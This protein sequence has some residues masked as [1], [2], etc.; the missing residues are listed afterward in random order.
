MLLFPAR[1][2]TEVKIN[3]PQCDQQE[4]LAEACHFC[5]AAILKMMKMNMTRLTAILLGLLFALSAAADN[6]ASVV[7]AKAKFA[8]VLK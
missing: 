1:V 4:S 8:D 3:W 5:S 6:G 7:A 2:E